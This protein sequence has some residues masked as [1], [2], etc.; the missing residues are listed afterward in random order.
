MKLTAYD[1]VMSS[2]IPFVLEPLDSDLIFE[3]QAWCRDY[4]QYTKY[5]V[6]VKT[7]FSIGFYQIYQGMDWNAWGDKVN[8]NEA[9]A[10]A[11]IHLLCVCE[12]MKIP[13]ELHLP[14]HLVLIKKV[15][16]D[17]VA[18][19]ILRNLSKAQQQIFYWGKENKTQQAKRRYSEFELSKA[20][21]STLV[22]LM[23]L[24]EPDERKQA[25]IDATSIM[26][27]ELK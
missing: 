23:G 27:R 15:H 4:H 19:F 3:I 14:E 25:I 10:S 20:L 6:D 5:P 7:R 12:E 8:R 11:F 22:N 9:Y 2:D 13:T 26:T 1:Y 21:C 16:M 17:A 24:I 18:G